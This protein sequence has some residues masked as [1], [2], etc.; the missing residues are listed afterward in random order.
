MRSLRVVAALAATFALSGSVLAQRITLPPD[1]DNQHAI[2]TQFIG[3]VKVTIDYNSPNVHA[4]SG[5]DRA[6]KIWG[7]LVPY[8][9]VNLGFGPCKQCP[10]R[11]GANENTAFSVSHDVTIEGQPLPAGSYGLH[12]IPGPDQ[13][14]LIFSKN[15]TSW[16]SF[17]YDPAEDALRVNVKPAKS[18]YHEWLTYEFTDRESDHATAVLRWENLQIPWTIKVPEIAE[19][20]ITQIR[21]DLRTNRGFDDAAWSA[22]ANYALQNKIHPEEAL[23]WAQEAVNNP[24]LGEAN[25]GNLSTLSRALEAN[26]KAAEAKAVMDRALN[27]P[28]ASPTQ[29][30]QY[31]RQLLTAGKK[32]DA[33]KAFE[34]NAKKHPNQ[35]PVHVG[36]M[37]GYAAVGRNKE[38]LKHAKLA[39]AQAPDELNK[40]SLQNMVKLLE[41]GKPIQ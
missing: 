24:F 20:Y 1:G 41:E 37:R 27:H 30:H 26:D 36:L 35:W 39:A 9:L 12:M 4:P 7:Q 13:W 21:K 25:F 11:A 2:V 38:A 34:L 22:A 31:G 18:E 10:W 8:G 6:G 32:E 29:I 3:P 16:G 17:F 40:T 28:T 15:S 14:T 19:V 33:L 23:L 5:E